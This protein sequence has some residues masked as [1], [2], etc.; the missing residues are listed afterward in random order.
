MSSKHTVRLER[1]AG[2]PIL[3]ADPEHRWENYH[4]SNPGAALFDGKVHIAY[5]ASS[6]DKKGPG[7]NWG[8]SRIGL[9]ISHN[10]TDIVERRPEPLIGLEG[11]EEYLI[12]PNGVEDPRITKI[13]DTY[14]IVYAVTS[15]RGDRIA[16]ATTR[17][18]RTVTK[19]GV[20]MREF[21]QRTAG[22]FP[23]KI[24]GKFVLMHRIV[25]NIWISE[26]DDLR[27]F[28]NT[29]LVMDTH[30]LPW[31]EVKLGISAPPIRTRNAWAVIFHGRDRHRCYRQGIAWLD[32]E[33][34]ARV[35]KVQPE[36]I[37]EPVEPYEAS[38]GFIP[39]CVYA[40][41]A[42]VLNERVFVYYGASDTVACVASMP[43][44]LLDL[45]PA[46]T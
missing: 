6:Q 19:H 9:A 22:L 43:R 36:P 34:P 4:V 26:S 15:P 29:R 27:T 28:T 24:N 41:G 33:D 32:I 1:Y 31:C 5:R 7:I 2:N 20:L 39:N 23:E 38:E 16:L 13:G 30:V 8:V 46:R 12:E 14:Y 45:T 21:E 10:G 37:L 40:C 44:D 35:I 18:F 17:D 3:E 11:E 25:P 42:V